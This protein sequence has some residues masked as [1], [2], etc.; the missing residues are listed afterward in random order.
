VAVDRAVV[1]VDLVVIGD[2]HQGVAAFHH[3]GT[4]GDR[5]QDQELGDRE[6][7]RLVLPG[8]ARA[9]AR[10]PR[11]PCSPPASAINAERR[12]ISCVG[13]NSRRPRSRR[14]R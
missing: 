6:G 9:F 13:L 12:R 8:L 4:G 2:I 11:G 1:D 3:A 5:L 7:D 10:K 14:R